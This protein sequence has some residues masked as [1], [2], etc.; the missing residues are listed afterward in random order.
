M[1][2]RSWRVVATTI[3]YIDILYTIYYIDPALLFLVFVFCYALFISV[4]AVI[5]QLK[6]ARGV[7]AVNG[8]KVTVVANENF[9]KTTRGVRKFRDYFQCVCVDTESQMQTACLWSLT[10][11]HISRLKGN[12][13]DANE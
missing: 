2:K 13:L 1:T 4:L 6:S 3:Y 10:R 9:V 12:I 7:V 5:I 11:I 8:T